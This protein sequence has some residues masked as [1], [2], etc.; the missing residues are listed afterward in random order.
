MGKKT[1]IRNMTEG[2]VIRQLI[3]F[4]LPFLAANCLQ[5][6]YTMV[7]TFVIGQFA[8]KESLAAVASCGELVT[9]YTMIGVGISSAAQIIIAQF[10]GK[11]DHESVSKTVGTTLTFLTL[12]SI[13]FSVICC[14]FIDFQLSL[15]NLPA[16]SISEGKAYTLV[17]AVGLVFVFGYNAIS[18][19]LRGMGDSKRPLIFIA[20][21]SVMNLVLDLLFI[22][23]FHW[24]AF[25]AALATILGQAFSVVASLIYLYRRR[26]SF[27]FDF[28]PASF[29]LS[30]SHLLMLLRLGLPIAAQYA[31]VL[32]SVLFVSS[33]IN[34][35]G[36]AATAANG[37]ANKLEN[38]VRI[39]TNT[40]GIAGSAMI[41]QNIA[42]RKTKRVSQILG[43]VLLIGGAWSALCALAV[44]IMPEPIFAIFNTDPEVLA[45]ASLYAP[46][47]ALCYLSNG[48]RG[49]A[50]CLINGI[51]FASLALVSGLIDGVAARIGFSLLFGYA[52]GLGLQGF[53]LGNA[54][55]GYV[56]VAI[57]IVYY[58]SGKWKTHKLIT[59]DK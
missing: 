53:W 47:G 11:N 28:K 51:G 39:V 32:I 44:F 34:L 22:V 56:P 8:G 37:V 46:A 20:I 25:G 12:I 30:R 50:N 41:A 18:A 54:L 31:A 19:I 26:E 42:A 2:S 35:F 45:Y 33:R 16:E 15:I 13:V 6:F 40:V 43:C 9:F 59:Q 27:G 14:V 48:L 36:V 21:A 3:S 38:V 29:R 23:V 4:C 10:V 5:T 17:S 57:G 58:L 49:A 52:L 24:D 1:M 55:A 7:D